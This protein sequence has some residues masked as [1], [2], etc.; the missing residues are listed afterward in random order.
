VREA[1]VGQRQCRER[2]RRVLFLST[3]S[4]LDES[5]QPL[6]IAK[7]IFDT[8]A[9]QRLFAIVDLLNF[10]HDAV[11]LGALVR[12]V[13]GLGCFALSDCPYKQAT[14]ALSPSLMLFERIESTTNHQNER[15]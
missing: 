9:D 1:D 15:E 3:G 12:E 10:A 4:N 2:T 7:H 13:L 6:D 14:Q 5:P 8:R 11:A